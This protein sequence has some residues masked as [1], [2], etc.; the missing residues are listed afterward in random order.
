MKKYFGTD[1]IRDKAGL[2][3]MSA[4]FCYKIGKACGQYFS[5]TD[6]LSKNVIIGKDT[7]ISGDMIESAL[8]SGLT[9]CG[10]SVYKV[11]IAPTPVISFLT[12][13][14]NCI[15]G[16]VI[17][18]SHNPYIDN[19]IKFFGPDGNKLSDLIEIEIEKLIDTPLEINYNEFHDFGVIFEKKNEI[20][21]YIDFYVNDFL[22][23]LKDKKYKDK[24]NKMKVLLDASNGASYSICKKIFS[25]IGFK[26]V[27][28]LFSDP[29]GKNINL[30]CGSTYPESITNYMKIHKY[31]IGFSFDGD[32]DR[33]LAIDEN[34]RLLDGDYLI[35]F[36]AKNYKS[37]NLLSNNLVVTTIMANLGLEK[38]L[39]AADIDIEKTQVGDRYVKENMDKNESIIGGEQSGHI[40]LKHKVKSGDG[41]VTALEVL[42]Y[43]IKSEYENFSDNFKDFEK[44]PQILENV[45]VS[46]AMK[47]NWKEI[48]SI[49]EKI[50]DIEKK[51]D[52]NGRVLV[53][54]SGTENKLRVMI[55]GKNQTEIKNYCKI[56]VDEIKKNI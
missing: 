40:I 48:S 24:I 41:I 42:K 34:A 1:G 29:D 39:L 20:N 27:K 12:N 28:V 56:I 7:R 17:S 22:E 13:K 21:R 47:Q 37:E 4:E 43:F 3:F 15:A 26:N 16:I 46:S 11:G 9:S 54:P 25:K 23:S 10:I 53:R 8:I 2:N 51:L 55:E 38:A 14:L 31:D 52:N 19:G 35:Y 36:L 44:F 33:V 6:K 30:N 18:A 50:V 32:A 5:N 49:K 45:S